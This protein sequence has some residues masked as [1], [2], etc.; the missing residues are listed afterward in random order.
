MSAPPDSTP[1]P[2]FAQTPQFW[3]L[4]VNAVGLGVFGAVAA[5]LFMGLIGLGDNWYT[6][7]DPGWFGGQWWW[8]GVTA[9][10]GVVVGLLRRWTHLPAKIPSLIDDLQHGHVDRR[11]VPGIVAVSAASLIGGASLG[12]EQALGSMGGGAAEWVSQRR[13]LTD[14]DS[15][16][17]THA[18]FAGAYGGL[19]S[20]T[21]IVVMLILE[22]ARPGGQRMAKTLAATIVSSSVSFAI[23]F[24]VAGSFFLDAYQVPAYTFKDWQLL[25]GIGLGLFAAVVV[26]LLA[27][28]MKLAAGMFGRL[29][30]PAVVRSV[31][32]GLAFG[33]VGVILPLTMFTGSDQ[34]KTV[35]ET[36]GT[37]GA[38]FLAALVVAKILTFAISEAS[39]FVGGPIFPTLFIG[40]TAGVLVHQIIPGVP[41]G[42]AFTCL[43][44]AVPGAMISAPFA[45]VLLAAFMT[46]LGALETAPVL[47]AVITAF[48]AMESVKYVITTRR[49]TSPS[50]NR[51]T[52]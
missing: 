1:A 5:L 36:G 11:S 13:R 49:R 24:I 38:G 25:A 46:Q 35:L 22:V 2:P 51:A 14:E 50:T 33:V 42:L 15:K 19:F 44:A 52:G 10:A 29:K 37:L 6:A 21:V 7:S 23:Y 41:L 8:V 12:P 47:I 26:T 16:V 28:V 31:I 4:M 17:N 18:G 43:L 27:T 34:L 20:S 39:G 30:V 48:L 40:G 9:A 3:V 45:L 32:G